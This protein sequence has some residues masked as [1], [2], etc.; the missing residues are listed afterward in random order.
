MH[1]TYIEHSS[2]AVTLEKHILLFD[3]FRGELPELDKSK[4]MIVF[5]SHVHPD[6]Y[7]HKC[8]DFFVPSSKLN[9]VLSSDIWKKDQSFLKQ[10]REEGYQIHVM[11]AH[12]TMQVEDCQ[13]STLKSTDEGVAF[14][15]KL[16][17][18]TIFHAGDLNWWHWMGESKAYNTN[19]AAN[20]KREIDH[21]RNQKIDLAFFPLDPRLEEASGYGPDYFIQKTNTTSLI[22]MHCWDQYDVIDQYKL[23]SNFVSKTKIVSV[24]HKGEQ[25]EID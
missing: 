5:F 15:I 16:E 12:D 18:R 10:K 21:V 7:S 8:F 6:H 11:S 22:P 14:L 24:T 1:V 3:Y 23:N 9:I 17:D 19:M 2:F 25:F 13:I 20:F 4:D